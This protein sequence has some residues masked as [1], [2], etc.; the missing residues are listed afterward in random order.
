V[1]KTSFKAC[2][3]TWVTFCIESVSIQ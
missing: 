3:E 1:P 2:D